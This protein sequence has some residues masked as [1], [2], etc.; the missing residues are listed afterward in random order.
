FN[1]TNGLKIVFK[2]YANTI[3]PEG[4][5]VDSIPFDLYGDER[6]GFPPG[7]VV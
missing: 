5:W 7:T 3:P 1:L 2:Y 4:D 6:A